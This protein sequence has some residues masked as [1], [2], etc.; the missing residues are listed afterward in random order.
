MWNLV[1]KIPAEIPS[2]LEID[3]NRQHE[4]FSDDARKAAIARNSW[5]RQEP[6]DPSHSNVER[7]I[8]EA[9]IRSVSSAEDAIVR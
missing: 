4:A 7:Q 9:A 6:P 2:G 5:A 3:D 1:W 8:L